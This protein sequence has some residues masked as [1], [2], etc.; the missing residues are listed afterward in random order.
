MASVNIS[1]NESAYKKLLE[2]KKENESFSMLVERLVKK[3]KVKNYF[4]ILSEESAENLKESV[5][6]ARKKHRE[7]R[8]K[9]K[10]GLH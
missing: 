5:Y 4:G 1:L 10:N 2:L 7:L 6:K 8:S 9:R 3:N